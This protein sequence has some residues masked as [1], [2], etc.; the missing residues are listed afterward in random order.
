LVGWRSRR[1]GL[2]GWSQEA[3]GWDTLRG[4]LASDTIKAAGNVRG[5]FFWPKPAY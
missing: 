2:L 1:T 5:F 4:R 3:E